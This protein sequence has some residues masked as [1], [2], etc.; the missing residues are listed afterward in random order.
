MIPRE[1]NGSFPQPPPVP[2]LARP[3]LLGLELSSVFQGPLVIPEGL[4]VVHIGVRSFQSTWSMLATWQPMCCLAPALSPS[5]GS[6]SLLSCSP[7][8]SHRLAVGVRSWGLQEEGV[9]PG[10]VQQVHGA[11]SLQSGGRAWAHTPSQG[12]PM[13]LYVRLIG[14]LPRK[15]G[16]HTV[17]PCHPGFARW[18][19][20]PPPSAQAKVHALAV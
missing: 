3:R 12:L 10:W 5:P 11:A 2:P 18:A 7:P 9:P 13:T 4:K 16:I 1:A 8:S 20:V 6:S 17:K 14:C 19:V 15:S